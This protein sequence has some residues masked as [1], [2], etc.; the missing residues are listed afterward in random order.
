MGRRARSTSTRAAAARAEADVALL[1]RLGLRV[2]ETVRFRRKP[3]GH[4]N[5]GVVT[6]LERDGSVGLRD[7]DGKARALLPEALEVH[8]RN[9]RGRTGWEPLVDRAGRHH[10]LSLW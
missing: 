6:G 9:R 8:R 4:W 10:Q 3:G 5:E 7:G 1:A 2:G